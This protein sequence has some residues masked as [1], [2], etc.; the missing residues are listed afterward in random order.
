[1]ITIIT[2]PL[3]RPAVC[4][5]HKHMT[6][7]RTVHLMQPLATSLQTCSASLQDSHACAPSPTSAWRKRCQF[8]GNLDVYLSYQS[9]SQ[10]LEKGGENR[11]DVSLSFLSLFPPFNFLKRLASAL[12]SSFFRAC[13]EAAGF[14]NSSPARGT[15]QLNC[16][17]CA[18][19]Q[20][21]LSVRI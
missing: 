3:I 5:T 20:I 12:A 6:N 11:R 7:P 1:M 19:R 17:R 9:G 16:S 10:C 14:R 2:I 8:Q 15:C 21:D 4:V 13:G 18:P